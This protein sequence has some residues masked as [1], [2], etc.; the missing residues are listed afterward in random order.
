MTAINRHQI[1]GDRILLKRGVEPRRTLW[2]VCHHLTGELDMSSKVKIAMAFAVGLLSGGVA[3]SV[4]MGISYRKVIAIYADAQLLEMAVNANLL[5]AGQGER[6]L[7][8]YDRVIPQN[9]LQFA[10]CH[11]KYLQGKQR[12]V[13][14]WEVQKYYQS[15]PS[16]AMPR[17][18]EPILGSLPPRPPSSCA[19]ERL[20][21]AGKGA[22]E[23]DSAGVQPM[24]DK[25]EKSNH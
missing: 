23:A 21:P 7:A 18:I 13:A 8:R 12:H 4:M 15:N 5:R 25:D 16:V 22:E 20:T 19:I 1:A 14:L 6:L 17:E 3:A 2:P 10:N 24:S 9:A 11:Q